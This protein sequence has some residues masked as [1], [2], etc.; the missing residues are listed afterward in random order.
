LN[1]FS[2]L[3]PDVDNK[4][5]KKVNEIIKIRRLKKNLLT[6]VTSNFELENLSLVI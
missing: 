6:S 4:K 2:K 5:D 3:R 1:E